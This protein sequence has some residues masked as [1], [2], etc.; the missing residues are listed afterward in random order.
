MRITNTMQLVTV[1]M[2]INLCCNV[3]DIFSF[4]IY[5]NELCGMQYSMGILSIVL[6]MVPIVFK[7]VQPRFC[8]HLSLHVT[9]I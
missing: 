6:L 3:R 2:F 1:W 9:H 8:T 4:K 5:F 7:N